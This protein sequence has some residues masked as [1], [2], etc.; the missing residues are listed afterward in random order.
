[1]LRNLL[2]IRR[3][4]KLDIVEYD[5]YLRIQARYLEQKITP[6]TRFTA[7]LL[8]D[9]H[10]D[11][12]GRVYSWAGKYRSVELSRGGFRWPPARLVARHMAALESGLLRKYTPCKHGP[13]RVVAREM[14]EVHAEL[15][16]IHPFRDGNGRLARWL[17]DLMA[18]QAGLPMP[19]PAYGFLGRGAP[20]MRKRY[21]EAVMKGYSQD[22]DDLADFFVDIFAE[23]L[24]AD[25]R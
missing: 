11:W 20:A 5:A 3:K 7:Q 4:R 10:R 13:V 23:L 6:T 12:L 2:H 21:I 16:L 15:I 9:M 25:S 1:V 22:Y 19:L 24:R 8:C 14:A 17:A 18:L